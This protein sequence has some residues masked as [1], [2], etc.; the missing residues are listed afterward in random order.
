MDNEKVVQLI[1]RLRH[2]FGNHLQIIMSYNDLN[3]PQAIKDY[4]LNIVE[5]MADERRLFET[6]EADSALY[7]WEQI[8]MAHDL[9]IILRYQDLDFSSAEILRCNHEP[10]NSLKSLS[11]NAIPAGDE[12]RVYYLSLL[13]SDGQIKMIFASPEL[14]TDR[15]III[16][17]D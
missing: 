15:E 16:D 13:E 3:R 6:L 10:L 7:L 2:D 9:G 12:D 11:K 14:E 8:Y 1:R 4:I 17:A 5:D